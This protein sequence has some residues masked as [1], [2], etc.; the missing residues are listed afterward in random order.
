ME[1][2]PL[3][4]LLALVGSVALAATWWRKKS[5]EVRVHEKGILYRRYRE[6]FAIRW[7]DIWHVGRARYRA[8]STSFQS[9]HS[10][11]TRFGHLMAPL[12]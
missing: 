3:W 4:S 2:Q 1:G 7:H 6:L 11:N 9:A 5:N 8:A 12:F 10:T